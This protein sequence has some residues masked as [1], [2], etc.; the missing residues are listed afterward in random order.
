MI[1]KEKEKDTIINKKRRNVENEIIN[2][3]N[4]DRIKNIIV[5]IKETILYKN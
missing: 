2:K 1:K 5:K 4:K 3:L